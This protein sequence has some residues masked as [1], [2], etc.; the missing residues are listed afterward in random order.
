[1]QAWTVRS[2]EGLVL[3]Q[4]LAGVGSRMLAGLIDL[5]VLFISVIVL[6]LL[7][8]WALAGLQ[9]GEAA[10]ADLPGLLLGILIGGILLLPAAYQFVFEWWWD[11][12]T[13]GKR[14]L[15]LR[16]RDLHA[17]SPS[18]G[19]LLVRALFVPLDLFLMVPIPIGLILIGALPL[20]QRLGDLAAGTVVLREG[21]RW[22]TRGVARLEITQP[23]LK[24]DP[25]LAARFSARDAAFLR[26]LLER[27][28][29][30]PR[31]ELGAEERR[32]LYVAT[33]RE[34]AQR[35]GVH[36]FQDAR[37]VL[38][39]LHQFLEQHQALEQPQSLQQ[40]RQP[41]RKP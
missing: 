32:S 20:A 3:R 41:A 37:Q 4:E 19:K 29:A 1:M 13:L 25:G 8:R 23:V 17:A 16:V 27:G 30:L 10:P 28:E 2:P 24:L 36:E 31:T 18:V 34:L 6:L 5:S 33:A 26:R 21:K 11:G 38:E 9:M 39:E 7:L 14:A 15:G 12:Q 40:Q 35:I 22:S